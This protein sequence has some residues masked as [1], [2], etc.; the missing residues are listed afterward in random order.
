MRPPLWHSSVI[1]AAAALTIGVSSAVR[2]QYP[3]STKKATT[4]KS[5]PSKTKASVPKKTPTSTQR[6]KVKKDS[7]AGEVALPKPADTAVVSV[8]TTAHVDTTMK[9]DTT[10]R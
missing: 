2:A 4:T 6:I 9:I 1:A 8:D 5:A 10:A 7:A 3:D